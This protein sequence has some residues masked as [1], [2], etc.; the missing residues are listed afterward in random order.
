MSALEASLIATLNCRSLL[1]MKQ[2]EQWNSDKIKMKQP[3]M[4]T[5]KED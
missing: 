1:H 4:P 5:K 3:K 2:A